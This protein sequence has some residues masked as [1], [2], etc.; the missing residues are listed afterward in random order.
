MRRVRVIS[1]FSLIFVIFVLF[2]QMENILL[3][4]RGLFQPC[5][6]CSFKLNMMKLI[7]MTNEYDNCDDNDENDEVILMP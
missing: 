7:M 4:N 5:L 6:F 1:L 2:V 3:D